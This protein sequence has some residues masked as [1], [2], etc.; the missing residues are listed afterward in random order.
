MRKVIRLLEEGGSL[1]TIRE[2]ASCIRKT[3]AT[4]VSPHKEPLQQFLL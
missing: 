1:V 4:L 3:A 2:G